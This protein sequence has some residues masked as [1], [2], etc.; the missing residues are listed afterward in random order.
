[1][2]LSYFPLKILIK[3]KIFEGRISATL[4][5]KRHGSIIQNFEK[6]HKNF[7][8]LCKPYQEVVGAERFELPTLWSQTKCATRLRHAPK[9]K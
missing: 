7:L 5:K 4:V 8:R 3:K 9:N 1:M 2:F 6:N